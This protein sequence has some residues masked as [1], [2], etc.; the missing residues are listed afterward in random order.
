MKRTLFVAVTTIITVVLVVTSLGWVPELVSSYV[1]PTDAEINSARV[2]WQLTV[3]GLV[4]HP[5]TLSWVEIISMPRSTVNA[6][7]ICVDMPNHV[8]M[9]G[10]W[11]GVKL[12][13]LLEKAGI[14]PKAIKVGFYAEDGYS[15]DLT[16]ETAIRDD[17][18]LA[19]EIDG[20]PLREVLRLVVPGKW[21]YKWISQV[22]GVELVDYD[23]KGFWESRGYSDE[24]EMTSNLTRP[25]IP[26]PQPPEIIPEFQ[27]VLA[28][29]IPVILITLI[30]IIMKRKIKK[31]TRV[32]VGNV[33]S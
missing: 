13:L 29:L 24:A 32:K 30:A 22:I 18:I 3:D 26:S 20:E 4:E 19:Y 25:Q 10:N 8:I 9:E 7:L 31:R 27:S 15:T 2:E 1:T 33:R 16:M 6:E 11:T 14:S 5:L 17:I 28:L 23:F 21:G 12:R